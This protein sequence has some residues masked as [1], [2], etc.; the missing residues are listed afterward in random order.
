MSQT[1]SPSSEAGTDSAA[2]VLLPTIPNREKIMQ[3]AI[4]T[5][6][7]LIGI[8][9]W[10]LLVTLNNIPRY[11]LPGPVDVVIALFTDSGT[12]WPA[13]L[14]TLRITFMALALALIGGV[15]LAILMVQSRL[16]ELTLFPFAV[17]LQ[18]T[19][20]IAIAPLLLI[21]A[22]DTQTALLICAFLVA[23]FPILSNM[24]Q[25]LK[26]VDHNLLNLFELYGASGWKTLIYLK[27]P[28]SMP[29]FMAGL[30]IGGGLALIAAVVAEFAAG[31]AG[32]GSGLAF[33][34]IESQYRMNL[35]RMFVC[36]I[37]LC[38]TGISIF[39]LTSLISWLTLH[40]WHESAIRREN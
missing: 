7:L 12:L 35:P 3:V 16:L 5:A 40:R 13:M 1:A 25:G 32:Q 38:A 29:Y 19:P 28:A 30:R 24:A 8:L 21:Y 33:R 39:G 10:H 31:S 23:F 17:V 36:L 18:V 22:P 4:P 15:G 9:A 6:A 11:I 27:I 34:L 14:V 26:S 37:M 20:I 2:G